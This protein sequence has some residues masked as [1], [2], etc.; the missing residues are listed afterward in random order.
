MCVQPH[1]EAR[2]R[3]R[4]CQDQEVFSL[5]A[6]IVQLY[7]LSTTYGYV[8]GTRTSRVT[9]TVSLRLHRAIAIASQRR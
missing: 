8:Y 2:R 6:L 9:V 7:F 5:Y 3:R 4:P 1:S